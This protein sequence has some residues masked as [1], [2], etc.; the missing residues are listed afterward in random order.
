MRGRGLV[1]FAMALGLAAC[2]TES[3]PDYLF[4]PG[5]EE[6]GNIHVVRLA[7]TAYEMGLQHGELLADG[8]AEGVA[9][10]E[11]D[12]FFSLALSLALS[13]GFDVDATANSYPDVAEE[14]RGM[15]EAARRSGVPGWTREK[16][17]LLAY[18]EVLIEHLSA[19]LGG[20]CS[21]FAAQG[22][23]TL[24]GS[25][26]HA[27]NLD[28]GNIPYMMDHPTVFVRRPEGKTAWVA[29][30]FPGSVAPYSGIN[31]DGLSVASNENNAIDDI[32]RQGRSHQQMMRQIFQ[33]QA[34]L[35]GARAFLWAEDHMTAES[36]LITDWRAGT[37][38]VFEMS[39]THLGV[40][41]LAPEGWVVMTNHFVHSDM[42]GLHK[43]YEDG[44]SS[45][46]RFARLVEL[47]SPGGP[48]S[49]YGQLDLAAAV[50]VL[51]DTHNPVSGQTHPAE[52]F[53][54]G[55]TIANNAALHSMVF[56]PERRSFYLAAGQIPVPP[57]TF[58]GFHIDEL[59]GLDPEA[60][61]TP[62]QVE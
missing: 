17:M 44:A 5:R 62:A 8:L 23:A 7:G 47:V 45:K 38:A 26:I 14:C 56:L 2:G 27:R 19:M 3:G 54:G 21:Q 39:A 24:D 32:D 41:E 34:S 28:W 61:P 9:Y 55:A 36:F 40:R 30:G 10:V 52:L 1:W 53:D 15:A 20:G 35:A 31:A 12:P 6:R 51:R 11:S 22:P 46:A 58:V 13:E 42:A 57:R 33:D 37:A 48:D 16:C 29:I 60:R 59:L 49:R 43:P 4:E 18:G 25:L 50:R